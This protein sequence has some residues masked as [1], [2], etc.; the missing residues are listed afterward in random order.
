MRIIEVA[1]SGTVGTTNMGPVSAD[2]LEL[3]NRFAERGHEVVLADLVCREPR[4]LLHR[5]VRLLE[6]PGTPESKVNF[7]IQNR[8]SKFTRSWRNAYA[9]VREF[10]AN[11]DLAQTDI[12]HFHSP[13]PAYLA[14]RLYRARTAFTAHTPL[15]IREAR[16]HL[17]IG[18]LGRFHEATERAVIRRSLVTIGLGDYVADE[19]PNANVV[20]IQNGLDFAAWNRV[21]KAGARNALGIGPR[22]FVLLFTGRIDYVKGVD[23]LIEAVERLASSLPNLKLFVIGPLSGSFDTGDACTTPFAAKMIERSQN[24]PVRFLGFINNQ[25]PEFRQYLAAADV[26]VLPSRWEP[27][28]MV[29][30]EALAMGTPVIASAVGGIPPMVSDDVGSLF[31]PGD[32][33]ALAARIRETH[34]NPQRLA[35]M[36]AAARKRVETCYS[37]EAVADRYLVEFARALPH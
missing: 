35:D 1:F 24:L 10:M 27:Q 30:L 31:A 12:V 18:V 4:K 8:I 11:A 6:L 33:G 13:Q 19:M 23:V 21:D 32:T 37:W 16:V 26:F 15:W 9:F 29:V 7:G 34:D 14:Q 28:G 3:S 22:D 2:V 36:R 17:P 20:T 5:N 25:T